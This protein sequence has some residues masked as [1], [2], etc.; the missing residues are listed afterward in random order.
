MMK[1]IIKVNDFFRTFG[2]YI[3]G[4]A[5]FAMMWIIVIDVLMRNI[6]NKP[7]VGT[8]EIVQ[9]YLMPLAIFP[10]LAFAYWS[11][12]L[13]RLSELISKLP[14]GVQRFHRWLILLVELLVFTLMTYYGFLFALSGLQESMAI[15]VGGKLLLVWPVYFLVPIGFFFVLVEVI[16]R[17]MKQSSAK[18]E[19]NV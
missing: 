7:L 10:A 17:L 3:S 11:G 12:V 16:F 19:V 14:E 1:T 8:Y 5:I 6:F 13:P 2:V 4:L 9:Y 18:G 15:P